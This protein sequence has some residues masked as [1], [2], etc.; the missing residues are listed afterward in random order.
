MDK[1]EINEIK[2]KIIN[3]KR[4]NEFIVLIQVIKGINKIISTSKIKNVNEI[5]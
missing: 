1:E 4:L 2:N 3:K 5:R